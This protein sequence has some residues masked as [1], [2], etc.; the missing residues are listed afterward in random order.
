M[1]VWVALL[2][3]IN[4]GARNKV[5]AADLRRVFVEQGYA[6]AVTYLQTGNV[7][8]SAAAEP[9]ADE[10]ARRIADELGV[11]VPVL[12]RTGPELAAAVAANPFSGREDDLTKLLVTF[13]DRV[14][15][16][17]RT[18][19]LVAPAGESGQFAVVGRDVFLHCPDGYG[20]SKLNNAF[21]ERKLGVTG[22]TRN[23]RTMLKLAELS[24]G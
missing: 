2:R 22:T 21:L 7:V 9:S 17:D 14:P 8:F 12:L 23:W 16:A 24:A 4:L 5:A 18:G 20:R 1:R 10:L 6:D 13:L 3:G 19:G 11:D 15:A